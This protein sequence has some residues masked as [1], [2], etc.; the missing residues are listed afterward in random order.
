MLTIDG[1]GIPA[2]PPSKQPGGF[3]KRLNEII[4]M[5]TRPNDI[6]L[7]TYPKNG[8]HWMSEILDLLVRGSAEY[9]KEKIV[10]IMEFIP[11]MELINGLQSPRI[12]NTH[13]PYKW[14]P[15]KHIQNGGKIV[16]CARNPK[17]TY[18]SLFH[19]CSAGMELG[20]KTKGMT[21][22][23]FF[24]NCVIGNGTIYGSWFDYEKEM[25]QAKRNNKNIHTVHF[26]K[27]KEEPEKEIKGIAV[28]LNL[29]V[30]DHFIK[31]IAHKCQFQNLKKAKDA[32]QL[33]SPQLQ[34]F[35]AERKKKSPDF[36]PP[37]IYRKCS[38]LQ[39][40]IKIAEY[41]NLMNLA[42]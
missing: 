18:V 3:P 11:H 39:Y 1:I 15:W 9:S 30:S 38:V 26:E 13:L 17:D 28:F 22:A 34:K 5:E 41:F 27:L 16:H 6:I 8:T 4:N 32:A 42:G 40:M 19:H 7:A 37:D 33:V 35:L 20:P 25:H 21:W 2:F 29:E 23:Q 31:D 36:K 14:F 12:L 10:K 24:D